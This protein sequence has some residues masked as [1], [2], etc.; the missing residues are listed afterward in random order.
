[1]KAEAKVAES[2]DPVKVKNEQ[3][4]EA[5]EKGG[6]LPLE[7]FVVNLADTD[8][9]RY[10]RIRVSLMIDDKAKV[11][12]QQPKPEEDE[13]EDADKGGDEKKPDAAKGAAD[14]GKKP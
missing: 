2:V 10:L 6:A 13:D 12:I 9:A 4:A 1:M 5:L 3:V 11:T 8:A 7:P 14:K